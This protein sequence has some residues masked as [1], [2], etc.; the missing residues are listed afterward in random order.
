MFRFVVNRKWHANNHDIFGILIWL[1]TNVPLKR[2]HCIQWYMVGYRL[3]NLYARLTFINKKRNDQNSS[4]C[5]SMVMSDKNYFQTVTQN[6]QLKLWFEMTRECILPRKIASK[7]LNFE[8][9]RLV[10]SS[11]SRE[12]VLLD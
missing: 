11:M 4:K 5:S 1:Q 6:S 12:Q 2:L 10:N 7:K 3:D 9:S 8:C